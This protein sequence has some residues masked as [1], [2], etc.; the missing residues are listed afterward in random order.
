MVSR[1]RKSTL[2]LD[3][4]PLTYPLRDI[5]RDIWKRA[6]VRALKDGYAVRHVLLAMLEGYAAGAN[7]DERALNKY[8]SQTE[9]AKRG[10]K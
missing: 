5:P 10:Q 3:Q 4:P 8:R 2:V 1:R 7:V 9:K 6:Q